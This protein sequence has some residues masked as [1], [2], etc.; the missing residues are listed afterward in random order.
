MGTGWDSKAGLKSR[1]EEALREPTNRDEG[2]GVA[3]NL[4]KRF[5]RDRVLI[6]FCIFV[7]RKCEDCTGPVRTESLPAGDLDYHTYL[8]YY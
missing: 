1:C 7:A 5:M 2:G 4:C 8:D 3:Q 6:L